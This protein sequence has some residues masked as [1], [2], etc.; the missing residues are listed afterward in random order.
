MTLVVLA[1][2]TGNSDSDCNIGEFGCACNQGQCLA[3]LLCSDGLCIA[4]TPDSDSS[5]DSSVTAEGT[6]TSM[7]TQES[8]VTTDATETSPLC[9]PPTI[10]CDGDCINP[11][12]D[13]SNCGEC[14]KTCSE[15]LD[16]GGCQ[17]GMC[18]PVWSGCMDSST[19]VLCADV[20]QSQG[21]SGCATAGCGESLMSVLWFA[22]PNACESGQILIDAE[23]TTCASEPDFEIS[24]FYR[25]CCAQD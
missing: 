10:L 1:Q 24:N 17:Q 20:C 25:C 19:L 11:L 12:S 7:T 21:Y 23:G 8:T 14:G 13:P 2:C 3:G 15:A 16:S 5:S 6:D 4:E 9:E 18:Q 22:S